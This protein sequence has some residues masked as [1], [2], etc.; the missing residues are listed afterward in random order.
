MI[1]IT[2][3]PWYRNSVGL[4]LPAFRTRTLK[5]KFIMTLEKT[6]V[7][8]CNYDYIRLFSLLGSLHVYWHNW[9]QLNIIIHTFVIIITLIYK[10]KEQMLRSESRYALFYPFSFDYRIRKGTINLL[11]L[12]QNKASKFPRKFFLINHLGTK[13]RTSAVSKEKKQSSKKLI[14]TKWILLKLFSCWDSTDS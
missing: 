6:P 11:T 3:G 5:F 7:V 14:T 4:G 1:Y 13:Y 10:R 12:M 9:N 2:V 8:N